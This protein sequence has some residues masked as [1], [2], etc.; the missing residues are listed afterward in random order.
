MEGAESY[1]LA[2]HIHQSQGKEG[3]EL[4]E[5]RARPFTAPPLVLLQAVALQLRATALQLLEIF[6]LLPSV[7]ATQ[8]VQRVRTTKPTTTII[9]N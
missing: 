5:S 9:L 4:A 2:L 6:L 3:A 8:Q 1:P 7:S